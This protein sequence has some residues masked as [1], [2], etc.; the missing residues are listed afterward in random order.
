LILMHVAGGLS[1]EQTALRARE[2]GLAQVSGVAIFKRLRQ[3][4]GWLWDLCQYLLKEQQSR[5]GH[6][7]WP[8][9]YRVRAVDATDAQ[10]PG[11]TG[12]KHP[13]PRQKESRAL[14][15]LPFKA[16]PVRVRTMLTV[17]WETRFR[18]I[19]DLAVT[20]YRAN[21]RGADVLFSA[22]EVKFLERIGCRPQELYDFV[23][24]W[25]EHGEPTPEV[26]VKLAAIR[27]GY[28]LTEQQGQPPRRCQ[29]AASFPAREAEL[30]GYRWLPRI[31]AK[32]RAKLR[33][34]LPPELM[35]GCGGDREFLR[36]VHLDAVEFLRAVWSAD[37]NDAR[38]LELVRD[39]ARRK[40]RPR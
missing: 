14:R 2:L 23:E 9:E 24:D 33:G 31:I 10:E 22:D 5:L 3:A 26:A 16:R 40:T 1:L 15:F 29:P 27:R 20:N 13:Q 12:L 39:A 11:E 6:C 30:G 8:G 32:A 36:G 37:H 38:L 18:R 4:Q 17:D 35:Y 19:Y 28:F 25:C 21:V 7:V 34:E